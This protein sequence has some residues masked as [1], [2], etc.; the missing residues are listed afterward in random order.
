M[1]QIDSR[2][3][4]DDEATVKVLFNKVYVLNINKVKLQRKSLYFQAALKPAYK[5][6]FSPF[7]EVNF[8]TNRKIFKQIA[9]FISKGS[10][11]LS[12]NNLFKVYRLAVYLGVSTLQ[13]L[14]LDY[15]AFSLT[16]RNVGNRL[17]S[18]HHCNDFKQVALQFQK[19][20]KRSVS[21]LYF[22]VKE[23]NN[24][25]RYLKMFC[26]KTKRFHHIEIDSLPTDV[27]NR[28]ELER[29]SCMLV[30]SSPEKNL[31][32]NNFLMLYDLVSGKTGKIATEVGSQ[33]VVCSN[34]NKL[35]TASVVGNHLK[36]YNISFSVYQ[37]AFGKVELLAKIKQPLKEKL[38]NFCKIYLL[39]AHAAED[40]LYIF[41]CEDKSENRY[42]RINI[43]DELYMLTF[44]LQTLSVVKNGKVLIENIKTDKMIINPDALIKRFYVE[45]EQKLL[46]DLRY[47]KCAH[48]DGMKPP[49]MLFFDIKKQFFY[50]K[51]FEVIETVME[52]SGFI[53]SGNPYKLT[54]VG[55]V[56]Y[57][58]YTPTCY[59]G[60]FERHGVVEVSTF[61]VD[62]KNCVLADGTVVC[63]SD[64]QQVVFEPNHLAEAVCFA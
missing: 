31:K 61:S 18:L 7:V 2:Q 19:S 37:V 32:N 13:Q 11:Q 50:L 39:F 55:S 26:V 42:F 54:M 38:I 17:K 58:L 43:A 20:G 15:F 44:C 9:N 1:K 29:F 59:R 51:T 41:Y 10:V 63:R 62:L 28:Y 21:G 35:V 64:K 6:H 46:I 3:P 5:D 16:S 52:H 45:K 56:L 25:K 8:E 27:D 33:T 12:K 4:F 49:K 30:I 24:N 47:A 48:C 14:C 60:T 36:T 53:R 23:L 34:C 22:L 57:A 40:K